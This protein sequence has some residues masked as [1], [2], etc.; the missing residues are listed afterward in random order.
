MMTENFIF[1][2]EL[3]QSRPFHFVEETSLAAARIGGTMPDGISVPLRD[4]ARYFGTF[5]LYDGNSRLFF[6][7]FIN[8]SFASFIHALNAGFQTDDRVVVIVHEKKPRSTD[9]K[10]ASGL[11]PHAIQVH[12]IASDLIQNDIGETVIRERHKFGGRPYS[13]QEPILPG[14]EALFAQ[15]YRQVLQID[16]PNPTDGAISGS[17][18]FGDGIFN[19]F[20]KAPFEKE[21]YYWYLQG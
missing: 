13:I 10:Y 20:W 17:W 6:S 9:T 12:D 8:G 18:P 7:I 21:P 11:S 19:L 4:D 2:F 15:G 5:P 3:Q 16:F 1:P 14:S